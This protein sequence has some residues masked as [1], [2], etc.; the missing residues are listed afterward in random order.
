MKF[1]KGLTAV[2]LAALIV[3]LGVIIYGNVSAYNAQQDA[4]VTPSSAEETPQATVEP[5]SEPEPT[6]EP[7]ATEEPEH[8]MQSFTLAYAGDLVCHSGLNSEAQ[9]GSSYDYTTVMSGAADYVNQADFA[10]VTMETT[11]PDTTEYTGYPMFKSPAGLATSLKNLG[12]DLV[13]TASNHCMDSYQS[14][15]ISTLDVLDENG[16]DHVGTYRTQS[17]RDENN[18]ITVE[19]IN[20]I[21]VAFLSYTYGTNGMPVTG[22]EYAVNIFNNDYLTTLSDI[23]YDLL[24]EDM[25]AARA[26]DTDLIIVFMHWGNEYYT[27]PFDFQYELADY[28]FEQGADVILGGHTHVPEP[29]EVRTV[30]DLEGNEKTGYICYCLG[31]FISCQNDRYTNLTAIVDLTFEKDVATGET[32]LKNVGYAPMIMID[33]EDYG[34]YNAGW[35]YR[36]WDLNAAI[37]DYNSSDD[38]GVINSTL[39]SA[40]E[41]GLEDIHSIFGEKLDMGS[42]LYVEN[43]SGEYPVSTEE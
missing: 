3:I 23:N 38:R 1:L 31:N 16:L 7:T 21:S 6:E 43:T 34:I 17:E 35:R 41:Q 24:A 4:L 12:F 5:S 39:Y 8:E 2:I 20:G 19:E 26:L 10:V 28:L 37:A 22:F 32:Y 11:F 42:E 33:L 36:L 29:M 40:L 27:E 15:L 14:G 30:T 25:A 13:N 18:G 9:S